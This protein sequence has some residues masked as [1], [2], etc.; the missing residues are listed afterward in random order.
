MI[1]HNFAMYC[2][3]FLLFIFLPESH[4]KFSEADGSGII[5][6]RLPTMSSES[7]NRKNPFVPSTTANSINTYKSQRLALMGNCSIH[8][9]S[10]IRV[11]T[12]RVSRKNG[13]TPRRRELGFSSSLDGLRMSTSM[14]GAIQESKRVSTEF[15]LS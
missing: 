14:V 7:R 10:N 3:I 9:V 4:T 2:S 8:L 12:L 5:S 1:P 6:S 15:P 13:K 11:W